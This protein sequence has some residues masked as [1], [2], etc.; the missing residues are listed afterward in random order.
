MTHSTPKDSKLTLT[1]VSSLGLLNARDAKR[2]ELPE[3]VI[4][5]A[6]VNNKLYTVVGPYEEALSDDIAT[7]DAYFKDN[8]IVLGLPPT[9]KDKYP[10]IKP[11]H[12]DA[13]CNSILELSWENNVPV[14]KLILNKLLYY[15]YAAFA[16]TYEQP[17]FN[18]PFSKGGY[19]PYIGS[20]NEQF[21]SEGSSTIRKDHS[22]PN[23]QLKYLPNGEWDFKSFRPLKPRT[24]DLPPEAKDFF[25]RCIKQLFKLRQW[26]LVEATQ[27]QSISD[28]NIKRPLNVR[29]DYT[30][31]E[32]VKYFTEN[33]NEWL[34]LENNTTAD[35]D[36][37]T[38]KESTD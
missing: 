31:D 1:I 28:A 26:D 38:S 8:H 16:I 37:K 9:Y 22:W 11:Q 3:G 10:F 21:Y 15:V 2:F 29:V 24:I 14:S 30:F 18:E 32:I 25:E 20:V 33:P 23:I 13:V 34:W 7:V 36:N 35:A 5:S 17:L 27:K 12:L 19:G 6:Y 4:F